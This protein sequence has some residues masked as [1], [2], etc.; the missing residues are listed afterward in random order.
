MRS[1]ILLFP[2]NLA[3]RAML[4]STIRLAFKTLSFRDHD[5]APPEAGQ[6]MLLEGVIPLDAVCLILARIE[7]SDWN[8]HVIDGVVVRTGEPRAPEHQGLMGLPTRNQVAMFDEAPPL[9]G[10]GCVA[11]AVIETPDCMLRGLCRG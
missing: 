3:N 6:P 7:L 10:V 9:A 2:A 4:T 1:L 5:G 11:P 8:E